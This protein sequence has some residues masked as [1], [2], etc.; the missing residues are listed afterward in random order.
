MIADFL[1]VVKNEKDNMDLDKPNPACYEDDTS[2]YF[3]YLQ[4]M[5]M[6]G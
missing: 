2:Q 5:F 3:V 1:S 6:K 4:N